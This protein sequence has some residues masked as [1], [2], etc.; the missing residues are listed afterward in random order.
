[1]A[2]A[3][4]D[5]AERYAAAFFELAKE[6]G[7]IP[8]LESDL[9]ALDTALGESADL[10]QLIASPVFDAEAKKAAIDAVL[11]KG[12]AQSL[13]RNFAGVLAGNGRLGALKPTIAAFRRRAAEDR[14]EV[15]A[16]AVS[17]RPLT[18]AQLS[19]LRGQI[20]GAVGKSIDLKTSV[21]PSLLGGLIVKVG[22]RM[23]DSS[24]RTKL[25]RLQQTLKEA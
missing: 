20:E 15:S 2:D 19:E 10:R 22:S 16:E 24:L 7:A 1:M 6:Q 9:A 11:E 13:T 5:V 14:G 17:A 12:G 18:D 25:S 23:V 3:R 21:D 8:A 4:S